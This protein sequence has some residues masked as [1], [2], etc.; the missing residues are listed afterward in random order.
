[1]SDIEEKNKGNKKEQKKKQGKKSSGFKFMVLAF[2]VVELVI[3]II[4]GYHLVRMSV[5]PVKYMILAVGIWIVFNVLLLLSSKKIWTGIIMMVLTLALSAGMLYG[6]HAVSSVDKTLKDI[7]DA[8]EEQVTEMAI[9]VLKDSEA[10]EITELSQFVIGYVDDSNYEYVQKVME[11]INTAVGGEVSYAD[12]A[13]MPSMV[14]ALYAKTI[15]AIIINKAYIDMIIEIEGY[16]DFEDK[17]K[18]IYSSEIVSY[19]NLVSEKS[20]NLDTFI[21]YISGID[22]FGAVTSTSRSDVNI[23]AVVNTKTKHVQLINTPRDYYV[24]LPNSNGMKDKL[25]HAGLYGVDS[26]IGAME[27]LYDIEIDFFLRMNF[28]GFENIIDSLGGIDV[29]SE[30]DFTV[31]PI[32]H[33]TVG[34]NHLTGIEALAFARERHAFAQGDLQRGKNQMAVITAMINKIASPE[35]LYN[36]A[37]VLE[38][39]SESFQ[40]NMSTEDI[41]AL[42]RQQLNDGSQWTIDTYSVTGTGQY[43]TTFSIPSKEVYVMMPNESDVAE[44]KELIKAIMEE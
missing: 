40:T 4:L 25:T 1:M 13:D 7:T 43:A 23:L 29:Y 22:K 5:L 42:V 8:P 38:S 11:E 18:I 14:D 33:Y 10:Q 6:I 39:I 17:T 36:Y 2:F 37:E 24:L 27:D 15:D 16:E 30:Y 20:T 12:F 34:L 44:V 35:I 19:M 31:T 3:S 32:K 28:S 9:L 41:Y 21:V 26:S